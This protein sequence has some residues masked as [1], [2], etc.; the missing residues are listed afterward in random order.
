MM[1]RCHNVPA[2]VLPS[3]ATQ[4]RDFGCTVEFD[5]EHKGTLKSVAGTMRFAHDGQHLELHLIEDHGHFPQK[6][7][8]GGIRQLI[9][10]TL[11]HMPG[12]REGF[13]VIQL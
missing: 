3:L 12:S 2:S 4:L 5:S 13:R 10:E 1:L 11:E 6:L 9:E 7:L 8:I